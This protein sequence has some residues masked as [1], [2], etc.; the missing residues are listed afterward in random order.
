[1]ILNRRQFLLLATGLATGCQ[2]ENDDRPPVAAKFRA[3]NAGPA[4]DYTRDGVY[5][6]FRNLGFFVVRRGDQLFALS[7]ICTHRKCK[8]DAE[9]D[10][11]FS[12]PCHG[13]T[14]DPRGKVTAG[15]ARRDLPTLPTTTDEQG[16]L[17]VN[18]P[19]E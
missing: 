3:V 5:T 14:F 2:T 7:S 15:P 8:L 10:R 4:A 18:A 11:S 17:I 16:Q 1:M 13:S 12:C 6:R 19:A 9:P